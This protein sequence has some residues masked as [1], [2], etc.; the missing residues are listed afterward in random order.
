M[1]L[2]LSLS[3]PTVHLFLLFNSFCHFLSFLF[4]CMRMYVNVYVYMFVNV[5]ACLQQQCVELRGQLSGLSSDFLPCLR[6]PCFYSCA[7]SRLATLPNSQQFYHQLA[8]ETTELHRCLLPHLEYYMSSGNLNSGPQVRAGKCIK[9][10][11]HHLPSPAF[12]ISDEHSQVNFI[13]MS[14]MYFILSLMGRKLKWHV[15]HI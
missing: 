8:L 9:P 7:V 10:L 5:G 4:V 1:I 14:N 13:I 12:I 3:M 11:S 6:P 15:H 2:M